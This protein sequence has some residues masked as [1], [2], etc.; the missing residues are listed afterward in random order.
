MKV[1]VANL[2]STSYK[3]RLF[4]L[5]GGAPVGVASGKFER[6][7]DFGEVIRNGLDA[8]RDEG[9]IASDADIAAVGFKAVFGGEVSGCRFID[10]E[11]IE[12]LEAGTFIAPAHNPAYLEGI[13]QF[14]KIL[15]DARLV[16]LFETAFYQWMDEAARR[17]AVPPAWHEAGV[18]RYGFHG[19]SHKYIAQRTAELAGREDV[20]ERVRRLYHTP[21]PLPID[22]APFRVVSCH[23]GG[24]SSVTGIRD[25]LAVGCSLGLSPQ[26]GLPHNNRVGELDSMAIPFVMDKLGL[27]IEEAATQLSVEGGLLGLSKCSNDLRDIREAAANGSADAQLAVDFLV[28][29]IRHWIG[30]FQLEIGGIEALAFTG[31]IGENNPDLRAKVCAGL[32]P[33][34]IALDDAGNNA[35]TG[36]ESDISLADAPAGVFVIPAQEEEVIA[37]EVFRAIETE[38]K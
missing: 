15:P 3:Y 18:V 24:S 34:G 33:F 10:G 21:E 22:D 14:Q 23:L 26:S 12:A 17:Y 1:L 35:C 11:V 8:L 28:H 25:G 31:G 30:A 27:T 29:Q 13:R 7:E 16:A 5:V 32:V 38:S 20:A 36:S 4:E 19:A 6:V 37:G 2:G 9:H